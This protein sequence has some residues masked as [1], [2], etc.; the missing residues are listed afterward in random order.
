MV[1]E[2]FSRLHLNDETSVLKGKNA[3]TAQKG[4]RKGEGKKRKK[5]IQIKIRFLLQIKN[6]LWTLAYNS[7]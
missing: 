7:S 1:G 4:E 6:K 3:V 5:K 2:T